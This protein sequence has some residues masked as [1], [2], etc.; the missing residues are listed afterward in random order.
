MKCAR[1][2]QLSDSNVAIIDRL[3]VLQGAGPDA[4][5]VVLVS[6]LL[7]SSRAELIVG[8]E[9]VQHEVVLCS[10]DGLGGC[11]NGSSEVW[12]LVFFEHCRAR[13]G[14]SSNT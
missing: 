13:S 3:D 12:R 11:Q 5:W 4:V 1:D 10:G 8:I 2:R 14:G 6:F 7:L 9:F